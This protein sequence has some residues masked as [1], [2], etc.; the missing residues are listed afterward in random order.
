MKKLFK[1]LICN[2]FLI[3]I[4][5]SMA[6]CNVNENA[7]DKFNDLQMQLDR[8]EE[9]LGRQDEDL[10]LQAGEIKALKEKNKE[11]EEKNRELED[12][13]ANLE[14]KNR[15]LEETVNEISNSIPH[16]VGIVGT[17]G[18]EFL[19]TLKGQ[20]KVLRSKAEL[21]SH[22]SELD[23][24]YKQYNA[25]FPYPLNDKWGMRC[26]GGRF[27]SE[28][29]FNGDSISEWYNE[30]FFSS[31]ALI[32]CYFY[33]PNMFIRLIKTNLYIND[34]TLMVRIN[35]AMSTATSIDYVMVVLEVDNSYVDNITEVNLKT[36]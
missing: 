21:T 15:E 36:K 4:I 30:A 5:L 22:L 33:S 26:Q 31:K 34:S 3:V 16:E 10:K 25:D 14:E 12:K 32:F 29:A 17:D 20:A 7:Q 24:R 9:K 11:F 8:Q 6:A 13:I 23:E 35:F 18:S 27:E 19:D 28:T 1:I 2:V